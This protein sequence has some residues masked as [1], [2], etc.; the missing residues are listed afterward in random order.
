[1][2]TALLAQFRS[3]EALA[4]SPAHFYAALS[5]GAERCPLVRVLPA[6]GQ[7]DRSDSWVPLYPWG[8]RVSLDSQRFSRLPRFPV[9]RPAYLQGKRETGERLELRSFSRMGRAAPDSIVLAHAPAIALS[10]VN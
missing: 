2:V 8:A 1:M 5:S 6:E 3:G 9:Y 7:P 10:G 4:A